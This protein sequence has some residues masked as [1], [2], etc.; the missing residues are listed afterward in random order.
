MH[1]AIHAIAHII[2]DHA[3]EAGYPTRFASTKLVEGDEPMQKE[4][5][6]HKDDLDI[7]EKIVSSMED[8]LHTDREAALAD[9]R[10]SYIEE[11]V[12]VCVNKK[13]K[14]YAQERSEN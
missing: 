2:E 13:N 5:S 4:L 7:I 9:M 8:A 14:S 6:L 12:A 1:R 3:K 11:V 10:Y